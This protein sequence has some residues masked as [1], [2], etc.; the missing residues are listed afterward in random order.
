MSGMVISPRSY[1][2]V[3]N[4]LCYPGIFVI[5]NEFENCSFELYEELSWT[6]DGDCIES[7]DCF[8][9]DGHF[10]YVIPANPRA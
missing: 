8:W 4:S 1:F 3:E 5:P 6:F 9:L 10:Y 7:E 2:I